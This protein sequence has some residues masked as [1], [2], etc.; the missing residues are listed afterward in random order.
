MTL[1]ENVAQRFIR[2]F[3][4]GDGLVL[5]FHRVLDE[6]AR[7]SYDGLRGLEV[8]PSVYKDL[9]GHFKRRGFKFLSASDLAAR[10]N[11]GER[12]RKFIVVTFDDGYKDN[13]DFV[14]HTMAQLRLPW[15][16]YITTAFCDH[17]LPC[18]W[19]GL[20]ELIDRERTI[21]ARPIRGAVY[22]LSNASH[23]DK[24]QI[25]NQLRNII[26]S[27]WN[28]ALYRDQ[29]TQWFSKHAI[30]LVMLTSRLAMTWDDVRQIA[31]NGCDIGAHTV[32]HLNLKTS[33]LIDVRR[34]MA[35]SKSILE[36]KLGHAVKTFAYPFGDIQACG[37]REFE[38]AN[39]LAFDLAFT[40]RNDWIRP[41]NITDRWQLPRMNVSG[42]WDT[43]P[44]VLFRVN[45]WSILREKQLNGTSQWL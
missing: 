3:F 30:D 41:D 40:T 20:A 33:A 21:D 5:M 16:L 6:K 35:E 31:Q 17:T 45:G 27:N 4:S 10:L 15:T 42:T 19:Y 25:Y 39:Q 32:Q 44:S 12:L 43:L 8:L 11:A 36:Q 29:V 13:A 28:N 14:A 1:F 38:I 26:H 24:N 22:D 18:W 34:E 23:S 7:S 9:L 37:K 2:P